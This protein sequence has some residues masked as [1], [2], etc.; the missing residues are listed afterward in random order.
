MPNLSWSKHGHPKKSQEAWL[1]FLSICNAILRPISPTLT[2]EFL[3]DCDED[4]LTLDPIQYLSSNP[5]Y[6]FAIFI[7]TVS[8][9][10]DVKKTHNLP[11]R[12]GV[13]RNTYDPSYGLS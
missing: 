8:A 11:Y 13:V 10:A 4:K 6:H 5:S 3:S 9:F 1:A 2:F 12:P 7:M